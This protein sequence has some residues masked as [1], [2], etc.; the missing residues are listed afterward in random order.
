MSVPSGPLVL[1][2]LHWTA[3]ARAAGT[4]SRVTAPNIPVMK[5]APQVIDLRR[6]LRQ[7]PRKQ[8]PASDRGLCEADGLY[9]CSSIV[10]VCTG[11]PWVVHI[12]SLIADLLF[13]ERDLAGSCQKGSASEGKNGSSGG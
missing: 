6:C 10:V 12:G 4:V 13:D 2:M 8:K 3:W 1:P 11:A 5:A 9:V 7:E